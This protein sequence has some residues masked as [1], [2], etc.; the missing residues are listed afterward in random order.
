MNVRELRL[1]LKKLVIEGNGERD[2][3]L[4]LGDISA[5]LKEVS[6][7]KYSNGLLS[8]ELSGEDD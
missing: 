6:K 5:P 3:V 2:I 4:L 8:I 7:E 1:A